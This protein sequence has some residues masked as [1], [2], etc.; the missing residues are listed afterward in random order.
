MEPLSPLKFPFPK[1][2]ASVELTIKQPG[3]RLKLPAL[4][5]AVLRVSPLYAHSHSV[6]SFIFQSSEK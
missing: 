5:L 3:Q 6:L 1:T 4:Y 2:L